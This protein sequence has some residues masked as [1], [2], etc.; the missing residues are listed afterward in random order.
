M[1]LTV[2]T[3]DVNWIYLSGIVLWIVSCS[4]PSNN[5][6]PVEHG[7]SQDLP[8]SGSF[9]TW[10]TGLVE[11]GFSWDT[12]RRDL[13]GWMLG[14]RVRISV[15]AHDRGKCRT[16]CSLRNCRDVISIG[17]CHTCRWGFQGLSSSASGGK[18]MHLGTHTPAGEFMN[19]G[20]DFWFTW[21][22]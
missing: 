15:T 17:S 21:T 13:L 11:D 14:Q 4:Y 8:P 19:R 18:V 12:F 3:T 20:L 7:V 1:W 22:F 10:G 5:F 2:I 9:T 16:C 6:G